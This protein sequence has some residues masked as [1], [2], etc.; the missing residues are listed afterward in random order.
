MR[1]ILTTYTELKQPTT[2]R[3]VPISLIMKIQDG[4]GRHAIL[5]F[6]NVNISGLNED[7]ST[8]F[9]GQMHHGHMEMIA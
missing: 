8:K 6:E 4:G 7:I 9:G 3:K 1:G 5:N 2:W